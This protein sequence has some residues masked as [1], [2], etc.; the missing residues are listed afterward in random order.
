MPKPENIIKTKFIKGQSGNPKG[1][2]KKVIN[3]LKDTGYNGSDIRAA[4]NSI[5]FLPQSEIIALAKDETQPMIFR[6]IANQYIQCYKK[7]II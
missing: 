2:P 7:D 5:A 4:Y 6:I 1:R 3:A